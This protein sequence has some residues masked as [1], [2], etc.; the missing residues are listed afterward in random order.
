MDHDTGAR[1]WRSSIGVLGE[2]STSTAEAAAVLVI[3]P[4]GGTAVSASLHLAWVGDGTEWLKVI[5]SLACIQ[6]GRVSVVGVATVSMGGSGS[7]VAGFHS[8]IAAWPVSD[9]DSGAVGGT[10]A[11]SAS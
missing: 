2:K 9:W 10:T 7:A 1:G 3:S 8:R 11:V 6:A 5:V 4:A